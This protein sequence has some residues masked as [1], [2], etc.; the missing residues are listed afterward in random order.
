MNLYFKNEIIKD[1][2]EP[3]KFSLKEA[4]VDVETEKYSLQ[5]QETSHGIAS[6]MH[7][8]TENS[9][10]IKNWREIKIYLELNLRLNKK[11]FH[12]FHID[13]ILI[14][15]KFKDTLKLNLIDLNLVD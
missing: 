8:L 15:I 9:E 1:L 13:I 11:K 2:W 12:L 3:E 6:I 5:I 7:S 4:S 14:I 10:H